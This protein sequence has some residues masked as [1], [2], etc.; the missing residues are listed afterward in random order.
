MEDQAQTPDVLFSPAPV[1]L[2]SKSP[3]TCHATPFRFSAKVCGAV[4]AEDDGALCKEHADP[5]TRTY[6]RFW[7]GDDID[8]AEE[9]VCPCTV[10][11][12]A[13]NLVYGAGTCPDC[14]GA[15]P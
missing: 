1:K 15:K 11:G 3:Y 4:L 12:T 6:K 5:L 7:P 14:V 10:G 2:R 9:R 13:E 8:E